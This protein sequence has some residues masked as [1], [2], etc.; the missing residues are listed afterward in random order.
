MLKNTITTTFL[1]LQAQK[2]VIQHT[3]ARFEPYIFA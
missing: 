1:T 2:H 3:F